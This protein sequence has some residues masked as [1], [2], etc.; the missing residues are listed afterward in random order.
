MQFSKFCRGLFGLLAMLQLGAGAFAAD[1][2]KIGFMDPLSGPFANVGEHGAREAL[3]AIESVNAAGGVLGGAKFELETFDTKSSPQEALISLKQMTDQGVRYFFM[4]NGSNVAIA[5]SDA[6]SKHNARNP[7]QTILFLNYGAVD[8]SLTNDKCSFWHFRFDADTD[9]KMQALTSYMAMQK[10]IKKVYLINQDYAFGQGVSRAAR[11]MLAQKRPDVEI[12]GDDLHPVGKVKDFAP[13]VSKVKASGADSIIT[14][15]WGSDMSLLVKAVK[16]SGLKADLYTYYSGIVGG[17]TAIGQAG[18]D[19]RQ[20][21]M[22][23]T[24]YGGK[25]SDALTEGYR[26][27]FPDVKDDFFFLSLINGF[28]MLA[29]AMN[30]AKSTDPEKVAKALEGMKHQGIT[31]EV[32]MRA[33]NHQL[34]QP[35]FISSFVKAGGKGVKYDVERTG[36]GFKT[37]GRVEAKDTVTPTT[38]KMER[39]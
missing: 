34:V 39:P 19:V 36:M 9:M 17:P 23:H 12:V 38:C 31:G 28:E 33:D 16:E 7:N 26:K 21:S 8:P 22:W 29:K 13:Y 5:L 3:L 32:E 27:R 15:N 14:G 2:I 20:V 11:A 6:V 4:G 35:L 10:G 1:T 18:E 25:A 37:V 24:N 30:Q